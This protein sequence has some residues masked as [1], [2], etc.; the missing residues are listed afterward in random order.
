MDLGRT[1]IR[2]LWQR[3]DAV[4]KP[5]PATVESGSGERYAV[6]FYDPME[7]GIETVAREGFLAKLARQ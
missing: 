2:A 5:V 4:S 6:A 7:A 1:C 3:V